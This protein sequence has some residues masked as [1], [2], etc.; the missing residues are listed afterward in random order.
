MYLILN[1]KYIHLTLLKFKAPKKKKKIRLHA[2]DLLF[3]LNYM[4]YTFF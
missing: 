2:F 1:I 3:K 4:S